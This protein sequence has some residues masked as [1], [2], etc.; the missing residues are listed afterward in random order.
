MNAE[1]L[2]R[3]LGGR[4]TGSHWM[5]LCPTHEDSDPSLSIRDANDGKVLV[6][7]HAGCDQSIVIGA[8]R[9]RG[10]WGDTGEYCRRTPSKQPPTASSAPPA[11]DDND[12]TA[13]ALRLWRF[14]LP[15]VGTPVAAYLH[16]RGISFAAPDSI[17]FHSHLKH[18]SGGTWPGMVALVTRGPDGESV[19]I[20][21]TYLS[22]DGNRKAPVTPQKM[23]LGPCRG[24]AVRLATANGKL[25]VGEGIETCLAAMQATG[26]PAWAALST[27][28]LRSLQLPAE[29]DEVIILADGDEPGEAAAV[30]AAKRW[31]REGRTVRIAR[32]PP[33][34][35]FNDVLHSR[36]AGAQEGAA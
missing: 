4:R 25:M 28:G 29:I 18:P 11:Q 3:A 34:M 19:A 33:G 21:R 16:S 1:T 26:L 20:H 22:R 9:S 10:L 35:D 23:M 14:T 24:G 8:L 15:A 32:P 36:Q 27:S 2:A 7:C 13:A 12:R 5:A 17:R 6:H 31:K 30:T